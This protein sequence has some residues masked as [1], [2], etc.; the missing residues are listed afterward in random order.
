MKN[1]SLTRRVLS[2]M[3]AAILTLGLLAPLV[4]AAF[5]AN[6]RFISEI[7]V[8]TG[9]DAEERL[10][11]DDWSVMSVGLNMGVELENQMLLAYKK[12]TGDPVTNVII[13]PNVGETYTD[14]S[15]IV[16]TR[17]SEVDVDEG[18]GGGTG[19]VYYTKDERAG[20]PLVGLDVLR[21]SVESEENAVTLYPITNDGAEIV[22]TEKGV[23][24]DL[25][26]AGDKGVIYLA[27]IR[28]GI[29]CPYISEIGVVV[30]T[31][32]W[33]AI[34]TASERGYNYYVD[35]DI[36]NSDETYTIVVY[37]RT[38]DPA[39]AVTNIA[40]VA[41]STVETLEE[42]QTIDSPTGT[43]DYVTSDVIGISGARYVRTSST[44]I[45]SEESYY[46]YQ[47]KDPM[48]GNPISMLYAETLSES[49]NYLYRLRRIN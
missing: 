21:A 7:T 9:A 26:A 47:T 25:E 43:S 36:D 10:D 46:L 44:P 14:G 30:D 41:A 22:L 31:D 2:L 12:N 35:G 37:K 33:N 8:D 18:N 49:E 42:T 40:A 17:A 15:G 1:K 19:C 13:S 5:A 48:A 39:Q 29:V 23:P 24:A 45:S 11:A 4:P 34:Y 6:T 38:A 20:A 3:T 28:D 32:K 27:Q 16:Y